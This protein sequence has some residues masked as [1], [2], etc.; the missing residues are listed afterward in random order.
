MAGIPLVTKGGPRSYTP[1]SGVAIK[2]GQVVIASTGGRIDVGTAGSTKVLG[3][4][5]ID[6]IAPEDQTTTA[7]GTPPTLAAVPQ[8]TT[9][10]VA[11]G[12]AEV[13]VT[14]VAAAVFGD[15]LAAAANGAVTPVSAADAD[16]RTIIG[17]CTAPDGVA[18][19]AVGLMRVTV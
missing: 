4:A 6:G 5:L 13:P 16:P 9:V 8:N 18:K 11:Y 15:Y 10:A 17:R 3:V 19:D 7:S 2:G 14:Y 1:K 12:G